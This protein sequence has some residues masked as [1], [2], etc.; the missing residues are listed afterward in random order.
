MFFFF[1]KQKTA[2]ELRISDW[3]SDVCSSDLAAGS[4]CDVAEGEGVEACVLD[5]PIVDDDILRDRVD[6]LDEGGRADDDLDLAGAEGAN[7]VL[8]D[9]PWQ[10]AMVYPDST[11]QRFSEEPFLW[12][13]ARSEM[14]RVG[15]EAVIR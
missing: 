13:P 10:V 14:R 12:I 9:R 11:L 1:F 5:P 4:T 3:S 8:L 6:A 2:Y 15:Q 7:D